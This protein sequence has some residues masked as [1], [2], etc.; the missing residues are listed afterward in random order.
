MRNGWKLCLCKFCWDR[1]EGTWLTVSISEWL[2]LNDEKRYRVAPLVSAAV[3]HVGSAAAPT[4]FGLFFFSNKKSIEEEEKMTKP[5][6]QMGRHSWQN[7]TS[8]GNQ[9]ICPQRRRK[10]QE[11]KKKKKTQSIN[12]KK[13]HVCLASVYSMLLRWCPWTGAESSG[14][15][16][17]L[18]ELASL[19]KLFWKPKKQFLWQSLVPMWETQS[20]G[21]NL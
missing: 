19:K 11:C 15:L 12:F 1:K 3:H 18:W 10:W 13:I 2:V 6:L 8:L 20:C 9:L 5:A 16:I 21:T 14:T 4:L 7:K 17:V